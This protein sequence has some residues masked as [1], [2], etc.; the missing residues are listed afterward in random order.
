VVFGNFAAPIALLF[1]KVG[2]SYVSPAV[3]SI[4]EHSA[5]AAV[6]II[7]TFVLFFLLYSYLAHKRTPFWSAVVGATT[8]TVLWECAKV[9]FVYYV[10]RFHTL[11]V[12]YGTYSFLVVTALWLYYAALVFVIGGILTK[13]HW[14]AIPEDKTLVATKSK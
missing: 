4:V 12:L 14:D 11:G 6:T 7:S 3:E 10:S 8:A 13:L 9:L 2:E 1:H 5:T